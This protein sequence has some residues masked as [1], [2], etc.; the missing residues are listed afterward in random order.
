MWHSLT[1]LCNIKTPFSLKTLPMH[2]PVIIFLQHYTNKLI[3]LSTPTKC[4]K[5][6]FFFYYLLFTTMNSGPKTMPGSTYSLNIYFKTKH[7]K[8][9]I[10]LAHTG[11]IYS[12]IP[13]K[14][15]KR[16]FSLAPNIYINLS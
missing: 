13:L 9:K 12:P 7:I 14:T 6:D 1:A 5:G 11:Q 3:K 15:L 8:K 4:T 10:R 2:Y 16:N